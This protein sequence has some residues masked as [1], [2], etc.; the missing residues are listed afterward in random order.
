MVDQTLRITNTLSDPT[1]YSIYQYVL[2][3]QTEV[4]V[5]EV[6]DEFHIHPNVARL[7]LSKLED[8]EIIV[9]DLHKT[10]KGGRPGKVYMLSKQV[11]QLSF[12]KRDYQLLSDI[13][14]KALSSLGDHG[15]Q[16]L[17]EEGKKQGFEMIEDKL[18]HQKKN[19]QEL[20]FQD[21]IELFRDISSSVGYFPRIKKENNGYSLNF[22][23]FNCP[24]KE[25]A[26]HNS[27]QVCT[28]H[29]AYLNGA[30]QAL[31]DVTEFKQFEN[32]TSHCDTCRYRV[33]VTN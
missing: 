6:A 21:K 20:D 9:S 13:A 16:L 17:Q 30:F 22:D 5:Q 15:I 23:I 7:H 8:V 14:L 25:K 19:I 33:N 32:M 3:K 18:K 27:E 29:N 10:G 24:F 4:T 2:Q 26:L 1:R 31:F 11:V 12:P 28:M